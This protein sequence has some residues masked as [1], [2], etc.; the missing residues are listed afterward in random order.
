MTHDP[1]NTEFQFRAATKK[2]MPKIGRLLRYTFADPGEPED[3][4]EFGLT[5][6]RTFC[7]FDGEKLAS[8]AGALD[9]E[10]AFNGKTTK[11]DGVTV[12][13]TDP[14]YRRQGLVRK[15]MTQ[16]LQ[17]AHDRGVPYAIL[18]ASMGA[19]Y[20]RFGY[21]YATNWNDYSIDPRQIAFE[22]PLP[23]NGYVRR[24]SRDEGLEI[25]KDLYQET[26]EPHTLS[27][28]RKPVMWNYLLPEDE[29]KKRE[30]AVYF[31][32]S[33]TPRG[34]LI[35]ALTTLPNVLIGANQNLRVTTFVWK[36]MAA[37]RGLWNFL[38]THDLA[39]TV[40]F[41]FVPDDDPAQTLFLEPRALNKKV[42]DGLWLR[43]VDVDKTLEGRGYDHDGSLKLK[44]IEDDLCPWNNGT[45]A[46]DVTAGNG[47]VSKTT[48]AADI[49]IGITSLASLVSG[50]VTASFLERTGKLVCRDKT[51][52]PKINAL[53]STRFRPNCTNMF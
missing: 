51:L 38:A 22:T 40:Q 14:S 32:A 3:P 42:S 20:Q 28:H 27:I 29:K 37:Y 52:L 25:A 34:Y 8:C 43:I 47:A 21:G 4:Q 5:P 6:K 13:S 16:H 10:V 53:F 17:D 1:T 7:A 9:F 39:K 31:D 15:L 41:I 2:E 44:V 35:Y 45:W 18:W 26:I 48:E 49:E 30:L 50:Y 23:D 11:A 36:D 19:I 33:G 12:V 46:L 24:L